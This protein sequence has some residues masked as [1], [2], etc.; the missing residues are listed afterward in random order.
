[1]SGFGARRP[2]TLQGRIRVVGAAAQPALSGPHPTAGVGPG[3]PPGDRRGRG[4]T[5]RPGAARAAVRSL[6]RPVRPPPPR[7]A[8]GRAAGSVDRCGAPTTLRRRVP[9]PGRSLRPGSAR[10]APGGFR[11]TPPVVALGAGGGGTRTMSHSPAR[12]SPTR[13]SAVSA[14]PVD[15]GRRGAPGSPELPGAALPAPKPSPRVAAAAPRAS[16]TTI[17]ELSTTRRP[18]PSVTYPSRI[19]C[20]RTIRATG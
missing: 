8:R 20:A 14:R 11:P 17:A 10:P 12:S 6:A 16:I 18:V 1:M 5:P 2:R 13:C 3:K 7:T 15:V 9:R 4:G 19:A